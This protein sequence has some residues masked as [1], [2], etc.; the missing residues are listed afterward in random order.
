MLLTLIIH[1]LLGALLLGGALYSIMTV[2]PRAKRFFKDM[3]DYEKFV[4][5]LAHGGL[6]LFCIRCYCVGRA[7]T[8][9]SKLAPMVH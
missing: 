1:S 3:R 8:T 9:V 7:R 2:Q 5:N 4:A 6:R